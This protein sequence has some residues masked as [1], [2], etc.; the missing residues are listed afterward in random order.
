MDK[1]NKFHRLWCLMIG[2]RRRRKSFWNVFIHR[3]QNDYIY[4]IRIQGYATLRFTEK[5]F[6]SFFSLALQK[7]HKNEIISFTLFFRERSENFPVRV[8]MPTSKNNLWWKIFHSR[9][10]TIDDD[11]G[12]E[13]FPFLNSSNFSFMRWWLCSSGWC[14]F[15]SKVIRFN[16]LSVQCEI[17]LMW[18]I[19]DVKE[20]KNE[21][22]CNYGPNRRWNRLT[23]HQWAIERG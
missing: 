15:H 17:S 2:K 3:S 18:R 10:A 13:I 22:E 6:M 8:T 20:L 5:N 11:D 16:S 9:A 19:L 1:N 7:I 21:S 14:N 23:H 12:D 4:Y